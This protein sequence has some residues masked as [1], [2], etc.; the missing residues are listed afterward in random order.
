MNTINKLKI[1]IEL[2]SSVVKRPAMYWVNN[3]EDF[4]LLILG[5]KMACNEDE[6]VADLMN[7]FNAY[8]NTRF[9]TNEDIHWARLIRYHAGGDFNSLKLFSQYFFDFIKENNME[10]VEFSTI[11]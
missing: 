7:S 3:V 5:F 9:E 6:H 4:N 1:F 8:V 2:V 11:I 10:A